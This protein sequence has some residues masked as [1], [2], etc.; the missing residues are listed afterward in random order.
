MDIND[1]ILTPYRD[2]GRDAS[3]Y[4]CFGLLQE[5]C[6]RRGVRIPEL[7]F[8]SFS[9]RGEARHNEVIAAI[10]F[11]GWM[12]ILKPTAGCAVAI[13]FGKWVSHC[14]AVLDDGE[15]FIH[16]VDEESGICI[17]RLDSKVWERR[18]AGFYVPS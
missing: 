1:L 13:R 9:E 6:R 3:G 12:P 14:G 10:T 7:P 17:E 2:G 18:I 11:N 5:V 16:A 15:R 8:S 4:D